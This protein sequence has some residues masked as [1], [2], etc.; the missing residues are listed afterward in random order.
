MLKDFKK[1]GRQVLFLETSP[2]NC[3]NGEGS[4]IRLKDGGILFGYTEFLAGTG[5][6]HDVSR[7]SGLI[8]YDEG[9]T[10]GEKRILAERHP[11]TQNIMNVSFFRRKDGSLGMIHGEKTMHANGI[12]TNR[13]YC[14]ISYDEGTTWEKDVIC[15]DQE[16]YSCLN[17]DRILRLASGRLMLPI[18]HHLDGGY[19]TAKKDDIPGVLVFSVSDDDGLTWRTLKHRIR[20][21]FDDSTQFQEPG[22]YQH[23]D[24][25]L[26][27]WCRTK[28]GSQFMA[29]SKDEG[30]TWSQPQPSAFFTSPRSP[31]SLKRLGK[32]TVAVFN[33]VPTFNGRTPKA[34]N[35]RSPLFCAVS[36][37]DGVSH[38]AQS[39]DKMFYLED[40]LN[41][42][43]CY[44]ALFAGEDYFL[45]AYYHSN[46]AGR[47]LNCTKIVKVSFDELKGEIV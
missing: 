35:G 42:S 30:E 41:E 36:T 46:G 43:Y 27:L 14:K 28:Y 26:W 7:I 34:P 21:P 11:G 31:M 44:T 37:D 32:Y 38:D 4:F 12:V 3:R 45:A 20:S 17:N 33:P 25:S 6:D 40:D 10:W 19:D 5:R 22:V 15:Y 8:S 39:F 18:A 29:Y 23:E 24:G 16:G 2:E 1:I 47:C 13:R 9:E